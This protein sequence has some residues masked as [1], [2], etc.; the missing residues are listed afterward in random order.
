[1]LTAGAPSASVSRSLPPSP[2]QAPVSASGADELRERARFLAGREPFKG[3]N[4]EEL[5]VVAA[6]IVERFVPSGELVLVESGVP[7]TELYVIKEGTFELSYKETVVAVLA[8]GQ[9]FGH[10]TLLTGLPPEFSTRARQGSTLYCIP[11]DV[12]LDV[13]SHREGVRFVAESLRERLL[14]AARTMRSLPDVVTRP[15][16]SLVRSAPVFTDPDTSVRDAARLMAAEKRSALLVRTPAGLG[17][18]TDLDLRDKVV[19]EGMS[20]EVPV[21]AV[22]TTP[23]K[24]VSAGVLAPEAAIEMM[25]AGVNHLPVVDAD[26]SVVG[27]L[28]ASSLMTLDARSP[29]ALRRTIHDAR[30]LD[31]VVKAAA[32]VPQLFVDLMASH[33]DGP[34]V[35]R[36]LT[37]L[38]DAMTQRCLEL[39]IERRGEPPVPFA[40]LAFG[41]AARSELNLVSDQDN[42]LAYADTDDPAVEEY[43]RLLA[44]DVNESLGRCGFTLDSHGTVASNWQWRLPLSKWRSVLL[45]SLEGKDLD[46]LARASVA[47]D[48]RQLAGDLAVARALTDIIREAPQHRQFMSG[49]EGLGTKNPS[50]LTL[51]QRL[52]AIIDIKKEALLPLQNL[53]RYHAFARGI[54]A[55]TTLERLVAIREAGGLTAESEQLLREAFTSMLHLQLRHHAHA[56]RAGRRPDNIIDTSTLRP[57]TRVALHEALR[58]VDAAPKRF[59][60]PGASR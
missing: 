50:A 1:M 18:V 57:L 16:T 33:L 27:I 30:T 3:L 59:L 47:F 38:H 41:S 9:V 19:G 5:E 55:H 48:F 26:G 51:F 21:S 29:F 14:D 49:L 37:L 7:G 22:M 45:R 42:G 58:E 17:I 31:D 43:F 54:T 32:D 52:P 8:C 46:R 23:V 4:Q 60:R 34:S 40:W 25:A 35:T 20:R 10:P 24:T 28:S 39:A 36:I 53:T 13:L 6:S 2:R 12:A 11:K 56:I 44:E 15:V